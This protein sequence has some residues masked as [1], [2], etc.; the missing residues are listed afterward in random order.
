MRTGPD[1]V[2]RFLNLPAG[3]YRIY[4]NTGSSN[5]LDDED[6]I[7]ENWTRCQTETCPVGV[8]D[9]DDQKISYPARTSLGDFQLQA[10]GSISGTVCVGD[11]GSACPTND[12][13][14]PSGFWISLE[15]V[16]SMGPGSQ[17]PPGAQ[18]GPD[19]RYRIRGIRKSVV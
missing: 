2:F 6:Y 11:E 5:V 13:E 17:G 9:P 16:V 10:G 7:S 18:V 15:S 1:G 8:I 3:D 4:F 14:M 12:P 19:G